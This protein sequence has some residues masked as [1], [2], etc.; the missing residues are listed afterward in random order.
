MQL[1]SEINVLINSGHNLSNL[2]IE[3]SWIRAQVIWQV[4]LGVM[5]PCIDCVQNSLIINSRWYNRG[6]QIWTSLSPGKPSV[7][8]FE[9]SKVFQ[10][11]LENLER[12]LSSYDSSLVWKQYTALEQSS[13]PGQAPC[14]PPLHTFPL[15]SLYKQLYPCSQLYRIVSIRF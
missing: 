15:V 12:F 3:W 8:V 6:S 5:P 7:R 4:C 2:I 14:A 13:I 9:I 11:S 1:G 10:C